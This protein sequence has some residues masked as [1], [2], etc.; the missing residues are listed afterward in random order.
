MNQRMLDI[1][2][3]RGLGG[4]IGANNVPIQSQ[5]TGQSQK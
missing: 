2:A 1:F 5:N 4:I 3:S